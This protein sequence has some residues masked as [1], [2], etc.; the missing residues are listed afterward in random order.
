[1]ILYSATS[2]DVIPQNE[3]VEN[4]KALFISVSKVMKVQTLAWCVSFY[5]ETSAF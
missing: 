4:I 3:H 1:M 5:T 2:D